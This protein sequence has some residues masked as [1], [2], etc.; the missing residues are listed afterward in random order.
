MPTSD[1]FFEKTLRLL[2]ARNIET[3][4]IS[5]PITQTSSTALKTWSAGWNSI[6]YLRRYASRFSKFSRCKRFAVWPDKYFS[7]EDHLDEVGAARFSR[8]FGE[9][10]QQRIS[11]DTTE[12]KL[13][14]CDWSWTEN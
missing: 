11:A 4:W 5:L 6:S 1:Y 8:K 14:P 13:Q 7:N 10:M 3:D 2:K 12:T 9:C